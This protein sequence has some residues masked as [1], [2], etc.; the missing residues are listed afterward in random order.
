[1]SYRT[2]TFTLALSH[3]RTSNHIIILL[4]VI[5]IGVLSGGYLVVENLSTLRKDAYAIN[6]LGVIRGSIQLISKR[7][8]NGVQSNTQIEKIDGIFVDI[9]QNYFADSS[10]Q[11]LTKEFNIPALLNS[12][13][14]TW[15]AL[16]T[17][18]QA[19]RNRESHSSEIMLK[20]EKSWVLADELVFKVQ[21]MSESKLMGYRNLIIQILGTICF[22]VIIIITIVYRVIH[23]VLERDAISDALTGL[24]NRKYFNMI[25][26]EQIALFQRYGTPFTLSLID[27]DYFKQINDEFGHPHGDEVL[28]LTAKLLQESSRDVDYT[29]RLGGEEFAIILP[30]SKL[31]ETCF[32]AEKYR[33]LIASTDFDLMR[34]MT[35]SI[36]SALFDE[37]SS[38]ESI[39]RNADNAL[40]E[41]KH[42]GRNRVVCYSR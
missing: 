8:L 21:K 32:Y 33:K 19:H 34:S 26:S 4:S 24:Y 28:K 10:N 25:L 3:M 14:Q 9:K 41:A 1:M 31:E 27:I 6:N 35:V 22:F 12:L 15:R 30:Q 17:L 40:Y 36:G 38:A 5:L 2:K 23:K 13:E 20:S 11:V 42:S 7:E 29:F 16:K 18:Y 39:Y 37:N